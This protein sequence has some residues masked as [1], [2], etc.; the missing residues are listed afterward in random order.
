MDV[1]IISESGKKW[2]ITGSGF[3]VS[4]TETR[5]ETRLALQYV[6]F[7]LTGEDTVVTFS[8]EVV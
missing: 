2:N 4:D 8:D 7:D 3:D 5:R 6:F 1:I